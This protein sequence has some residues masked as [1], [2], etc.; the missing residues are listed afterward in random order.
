MGMTMLTWQHYVQ[1][2]CKNVINMSKIHRHYVHLCTE[3]RQ[4]YSSLWSHM[5]DL[6]VPACNKSQYVSN[7]FI[8]TFGR[9]SVTVGNTC[10]DA[11]PLSEFTKQTGVMF[12]S[13]WW[14]YTVMDTE[15]QQQKNKVSSCDKCL[16]FVFTVIGDTCTFVVL[17]GCQSMVCGQ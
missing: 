6:W 7:T 17:L 1:I 4:D 16:H 3:A 13:M 5:M 11:Q 2:V 12:L 10:G 8:N 14:K 9:Q 15:I